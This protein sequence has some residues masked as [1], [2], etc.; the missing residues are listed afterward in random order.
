MT[1]QENMFS[2]QG[3]LVLLLSLFFITACGGGDSSSASA[4]EDNMTS[5]PMVPD[6]EDNMTS[7]PM[8]S[9]GDSD[10][11]VDSADNCPLVANAEQRN[12]D[13]DEEGDACDPDDDN[14]GE[15]D[16]ADNCPLV[17]NAEQ[18]DTDGD[19]EGD[20][21]DPD[22]DNDGELDGAD[23]CPLVANAEQQNTDG[24]EK[25]DACDEDIDGDEVVNRLDAFPL[26]MAEAVD[27]DGD[28]IGN[29]AD[30]CPNMKN[31]SVANQ[32]ATDAG[33]LVCHE[34]YDFDGDGFNNAE[35]VDDDND[36]LIELRTAE[37]LNNSRQV[38]DGSGMYDVNA[39]NNKSA[40]GCPAGGCVG[41]ELAADIDLMDYATG[42]G[43]LPLGYDTISTFSVGG[44]EGSP[45]NAD[46]DGNNWTISNLVQ[47]ASQHDFLGLFG[48]IEGE[49]TIKR[50]R[51]IADTVSGR[52][53]TG[54]IAG[55]AEGG[56]TISLSHIQ[57]K[58]LLAIENFL[59]GF[60]GQ[61]DR[62]KIFS[63]SVAIDTMVS[64]DANCACGGLVGDA[65]QGTTIKNSIVE[66]GIMRGQNRIGG[67]LG[68][69]RAEIVSSTARIV[70]FVVNAG[71]GGLVGVGSL[72]AISS[73]SI[74]GNIAIVPNFNISSDSSSTGVGGL[75]GSGL[76]ASRITSSSAQ[77]GAIEAGVSVGG[78]V[79][80]AGS[81]EILSSYAVVGKLKGPAAAGG[82]VGEG[83]SVEI[84]SSYAQV[85][86]LEGGAA[87]GGLVGEAG[88]VEIRSSYA[89]VD[90]LE[91]GVS[92][93]GLVGESNESKI[94]ASFAQVNRL[95]GG[96][97][98]GGFIGS[99]SSFS[100]LNATRF[101]TI[102][103]SYAQVN[104]IGGNDTFGGFMGFVDIDARGTDTLA[105]RF[106]YAQTGEVG[107]KITSVAGLIGLVMG[108]LSRIQTNESYWDGETSAVM[109]GVANGTGAA[110]P[111]G[112]EA[113]RTAELQVPYAEEGIYA[114]W[115]RGLD[116]DPLTVYCDKNGDGMISADSTA[117]E[118]AERNEDNYI[119]RFALGDY[120]RIGCIGLEEQAAWQSGYGLDF[121]SP[122]LP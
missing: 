55:H 92:T 84:R 5:P 110:V 46:F 71:T 120:P 4:Q 66:I 56:V 17:A 50:L 73:H 20:A 34:S 82:L 109:I 32:T 67:F 115:T 90:E 26:N 48:F 118:E 104:E 72:N 93:G 68:N 77:V 117:G 45:W 65:D 113:K 31:P 83:G 61:G 14:D 36:G 108:N 85:D 7:P 13:G 114:N 98:I 106:S 28:G 35:D 91:G 70:S 76:G 62:S 44:Y 3:L 12:T 8:V 87:T 6:G 58:R 96:S 27:S 33:S 89:Q 122:S 47:N 57:A 86:E 21:C 95:A 19:E 103:S 49:R 2:K 40:V 42:R 30:N 107:E 88:S 69:G 80:E 64:E 38:L 37:E 121:L 112:G 10:G 9:D 1:M 18:R 53:N 81:A 52:Q 119:W 59:G 63:S 41:Y 78:L 100:F 22:D 116:G 102:T 25:G 43:W 24:D 94:I 54:I 101:S 99:F 75:I 60:I 51:I 79:G 74:I 97:H 23:N 29:N 15:L 111:T 105:I 11:I 39:E 16:G